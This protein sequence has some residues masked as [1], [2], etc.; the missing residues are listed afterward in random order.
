MDSPAQ[1]EDGFGCILNNLTCV[2]T[3]WKV[4]IYLENL[5]RNKDQDRCSGQLMLFVFKHFI[6]K[7]ITFTICD[8]IFQF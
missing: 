4:F 7:T 1:L 3:K 8:N 2:N 6:L 5:S